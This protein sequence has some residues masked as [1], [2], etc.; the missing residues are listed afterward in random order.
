VK[1]N[2]RQGDLLF[3][4]CSKEDNPVKTEHLKRINDG[5]L[6]RGE[7]TGHKH[8]LEVLD[9]AEI[10]QGYEG[11]LVRVGTEGVRII[12]EEHGPVALEP[13]T[14]Y[15]VHRARE[16]DYLENIARIVAD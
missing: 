8:Q 1:Y 9:A 5:T 3:I 15:K 4:P 7:A 10:F 11:M 2:I 6:A 13:N 14:D 12:H 16:F